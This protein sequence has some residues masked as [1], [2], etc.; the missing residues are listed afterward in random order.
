[1]QLSLQSNDVVGNPDYSILIKFS[2]YVDDIKNGKLYCN[3]LN[4]FRHVDPSYGLGDPMEGIVQ[5]PYFYDR[6]TKKMLTICLD[7]NTNFVF[8]M[9]CLPP[10]DILDSGNDFFELNENQ[11]KEFSRYQTNDYIA[12]TDP[13]TFT[14]RIFDMCKN[15]NIQ[16]RRLL[17][18]YDNKNCLSEEKQKELKGNPPLA[19]FIK[20][21]SYKWQSEFRYLF[22]DINDKYLENGHFI[23]N[24]GD[25][26]DIT[27]IKK[28]CFKDYTGSKR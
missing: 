10:C 11:K 28:D 22:F 4:Y 3:S 19:G 17:V 9:V 16:C 14:N 8:S 20:D 2:N 26:S 5:L 1:M 27:T 21:S 24:I 15:L 23:L 18:Q 6:S 12:I 7:E 13:D 25:I